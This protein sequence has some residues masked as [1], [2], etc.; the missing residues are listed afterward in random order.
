MS[1]FALLIGINYENDVHHKL[2]GC[3][4]DVRNIKKVL[5]SVLDYPESNM[6][7]LGRGAPRCATI[8]ALARM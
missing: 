5:H 6:T 4:N 3:I 1:K 2:N 8:Q 7:I